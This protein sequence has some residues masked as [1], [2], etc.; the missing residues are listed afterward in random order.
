MDE[1]D[2]ILMDIKSSLASIISELKEFKRNTSKRLDV[3][4]ENFRVQGKDRNVYCIA[5]ITTII[6]II[7]CVVQFISWRR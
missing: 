5:L 1:K 2:S 4:E 7:N 6:G 3:L